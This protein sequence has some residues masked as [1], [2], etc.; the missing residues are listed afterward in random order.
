MHPREA[1]DFTEP[2]CE[3]IVVPLLNEAAAFYA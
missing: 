3:M 2:Y 1:T